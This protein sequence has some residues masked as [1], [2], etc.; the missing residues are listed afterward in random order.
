MLGMSEGVQWEWSPVV[1]LIFFYKK[2]RKKRA[3]IAVKMRRAEKDG[4]FCSSQCQESKLK[5]SYT[6]PFTL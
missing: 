2:K 3:I 1:V 6:A 5:A 4:Y